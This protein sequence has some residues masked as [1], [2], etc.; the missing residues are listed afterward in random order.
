MSSPAPTH[1]PADT[2]TL[3]NS[4]TIPMNPNHKTFVLY[5]G[6]C[7][8]GFG[9][10]WAAW[11]ALGDSATYLPV[12]YGHPVPE[13]VEGG[14]DV[15]IVDFS[16]PREILEALRGRVR[17]LLVLDHHATAKADL[18]GLD[19]ARFDT[20]KSGAV[21]A[22]EHF[23]PGRPVPELIRYLQ[24]RDLWQWQL[25]ES[26][27]VSAALRLYPMDFQVWL[28]LAENIDLLRQEGRVAVRVVLQQAERTARR[29]V[30]RPVGEHLV[31]VVNAAHFISEIGHAMLELY[32][33][34]PFTASY[35]DGDDGLRHWSLRARKDFDCSAV[36]KQFGGGGH[37]QASGFEQRIPDPT[38]NETWKPAPEIVRE[39]DLLKK[40]YDL[41][42]GMCEEIVTELRS[43]GPSQR[44]SWVL[45]RIEIGTRDADE[46]KL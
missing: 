25:P 34:A 46:M 15:L 5:H 36:A 19:Y 3:S 23:F 6:S 17:S 29:A 40:R 44:N 9:A 4:H 16:Y 33:E 39:R 41:L 12:Y 27:E 11:L 1:E 26:R 13:Q 21:L 22:W 32:P 45:R 35:F 38:V 42:M 10:A 28:N 18:A 14:S 24:D 7:A 8:D 30:W 20:S 31:P 37:P 43:Y 2:P